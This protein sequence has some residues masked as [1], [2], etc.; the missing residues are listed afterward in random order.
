MAKRRKSTEEEEEELFKEPEFDEKAYLI[1]EIKKA[2]GIIVVF[3]LAFVIGLISGYLQVYVS[4]ALA[5]ILGFAVLFVL[6]P[7]LQR[8]NAEF[9]RRSTWVYAIIM[10]L[11]IWFLAWSVAINP[12]FNDVSP[13]QI[14]SIE[15]YNGTAWVTIYSYYR[16]VDNKAIHSINWK[17]SHEIRVRASDNVAV[18]GVEIN[19]ETANYKEGYYQVS[20]ETP[21]KILVKVW[22]EKGHETSM[23]IT[24]PTGT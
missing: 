13:P 1:S 18:S 23:E 6:K 17:G 15:V 8:L 4:V 21:G 19:G 5:A 2:K 3:L 22:D 10:F 14:R 9:D 24:V 11:L 20:V 7:L 12:P 16:G